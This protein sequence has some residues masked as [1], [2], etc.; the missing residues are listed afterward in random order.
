MSAREAF[1]PNLRRFR[2]INE[3][4][5]PGAAGKRVAFLHPSAGQGVL[6]ELSEGKRGS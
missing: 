4:P 3:N 6:I 2:L 1:G 5:V